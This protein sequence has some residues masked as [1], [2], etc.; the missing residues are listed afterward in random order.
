MIVL[1]CSTALLQVQ[2]QHNQPPAYK[3]ASLP[4]ETRVKD[5]LARM[6][7]EEKAG[8]LLTLLGWDMYAKNG[9]AVTTSAA[10]EK[11]VADQHIGMLW[12]TFR[13]DPWT[14]KTLE[15]GLTPALAAKAA[16]ALQQYVITHTRLGIP[17]LLSEECAHG[18]MAIGTTVFPTSIGQASTWD[19]PLIQQMAAA[20]AREARAQ[21]AHIGY[22]PV[23][24]LAREPRWSRMEETFGEDP[25][26]ITAMGTA[27][28]QGFQGTGFNTDHT[29]ISTLKHFAA[30]GS[31]EGGHNGGIS[32]TGLRELQEC[33]L[34]PFKAAVQAGAASVMTS[35]NAI[36]GV[37]CS[38]NAWLLQ[39]VLRKQWGFKGFTV[40]D[41]GAI[42]GLQFTHHVAASKQE[43]AAMALKAGVDADLG[44]DSY[45]TPLLAAIKAKQVSMPQLDTAVARVLR[46]KFAMG[47][48]EHPYA[49]TAAAQ[50]AAN[51]AAHVALAKQVAQESIVLLKNEGGL[52][53]LSKSIKQIAVI[54]PDADNVYN[55]LGDYTAP[56]PEGKVLT[57]LRGIREKLPA[58]T[59]T[60]AKGCAIRDTSHAGMDAAIAAA[61]QAEVV[62]LVLGGSSAR[63]FK[64]SYANTGAAQVQSAETAVSDMESG[65]GF[66]R[67]TL[68]LMGLQ[69]ELMQRIVAL[70][71]PVVLVLIE[72]RPL[73]INWPAAH[74]PAIVNAWYPGEQGGAAVADVLFGDY[75]PA[76]RLPVSVPKSV[77]Q[78]PVYYNYKP[79]SRH[80]YVEMDDT[81]LYSFGHGLSYSTFAYSN[82]QTQVKGS[83]AN[84]TVTVSFT[85]KN[86]SAT[87]GDEVPQLYLRDEVSNVVTPVQQ[88]KRFARLHLK[89]GQ[90]QQVQWQLTTADLQLLNTQLQRVVEP[91]TFTVMVGASSKDI[92]LKGQFEVK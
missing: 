73:L 1:F 15:T 32:T 48:F 76:G 78:L 72:G 89:A 14:K 17:L 80:G 83:A 35:Y 34:P 42:P 27:M 46:L 2:A 4:V 62:V 25:V 79:A 56:Q 10:F 90:A 60:Y 77:G 3:N 26:L 86:T 52:L 30:Y 29:V 33:Y 36:D 74:V 18:H 49:D 75:N 12:A 70:G 69:N 63:D 67:A 22:G 31:P 50:R 41:L 13:A 54:G 37:P 47:L 66:D 71:K 81:P 38:A 55:Q 11:A 6:T 88:L 84:C 92:R 23:L 5:L 20:I 87:D 21:G 45:Y 9:T 59:V 44:G 43:A 16:N 58:A 24:D 28:V 82:L 61:Q 68:D 19:A 91:G 85:V 7:A 65:E 51:N 39:D 8:Q 40:S 64:T 57:I 53:P